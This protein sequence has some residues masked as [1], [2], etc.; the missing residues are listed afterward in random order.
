MNRL[1]ILLFA[2]TVMAIAVPA[3]ATL[4]DWEAAASA[5]SPGF[6]ATNVADGTYDIGTYGGEQTYEFVVKSNPDEVEP[7]MCLMG[8]RDSGDT[9]AGLKYEQW[10]NTGTYGATLFGV[11]DLDFGVAN[12]PGVETDIVFVSSA[13]SG[14][15]ALYVDGVYQASVDSAISLSGS[16]GIGYG[17]QNPDAHAGV[18]TFDNFDGEVLGVAVYDAAL[19]DD[20]IAAHSA[21]YFQAEAPAVPGPVPGDIAISTQAGWFSQDAADREMQKIVDNVTGASVEVFPA[22]QQDALADWVVAHTGDGAADL[23]ILCG[24]FPDSIYPSGNAQPDGSIAELFLDDG[25]IIIN[26][27]DYMFYVNSGGTNVNA[28]NGLYNMMDI[29][30]DMWDDDTPVAITAEG[31][32]VTPTLQDF[33]TDRPFHLDQL[34]GDWQPELIL[35][36]NAAGTRADPVIVVNTAT[37][38]RLGIF[39]QT[40]SQDNDPR[41]E[42]I[43]EWINNWYLTGGSIPNSSAINPVPEDGAKSVAIDTDLSW[44]AGIGAVSY[45]VYL[46]TEMPPA[47]LGS[48]EGTSIPA[49]T[50]EYGTTYYWSVDAVDENGN[51][52][53][54]DTWSFTTTVPVGIFEFTQD[55]GGPAGIGRTT[56]EGY[57]WKD[58][59]LTEQYLMMGGGADIWGNADQFHFAFNKV[60]GDIRLSASA[61]WIVASADWAKIGVMLRESTAGN[62]AHYYMCDRKL[63]DYAAV[64]G[65]PST[66]SASYE[67]GSTY[68]ANNAKG[69][70]IQRVTVNG[71]EW[72]EG[73]VDKGNGWESTALISADLADDL[74]AGVAIDAANNTQLVQARVWNIKYQLNPSMVGTI[75]TIPADQALEAPPTDVSGFSIRS[76]KTLVTNGS[77]NTF[78][79]MNELLDTGMFGGLPALPGSE[80]SRVDEFVNLRDTG[81]GLFSVDNGYPDISYPGIDPFEEPAQDP[82][83]GDDDN[84]FA[85]EI[86]GYIHLVPGEYYKFGVDSDDG[87]IL[88][89]G[90]VEVVRT[91]ELKGTSTVDSGI[92]IVDVEGYYPLRC[93]QFECTGGASVELHQILLDGTRLLMNDVAN[94]AA[95]VYAPAQ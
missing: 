10:N 67:Y 44:T 79:A 59:K 2:V 80:G 83:A 76:L 66:G 29:V 93:R 51:V 42:V 9:N 57:V 20:E 92:Y 89:I 17:I 55:I 19:S 24:N 82:A 60:S 95:E 45:N 77:F 73:L 6:I 30:V 26:T 65:R 78:A 33:A 74:L 53:P 31:H 23:L 11:V 71:V 7:S 3:N 22:D 41:G 49:G 14:T 88:E 32:A 47:L 15:T 13:A 28:S 69:L 94:G 18:A 68:N 62:S 46:G 72:I 5:A 63:R 52:L 75:P 8:R 12:N 34:T 90:G 21:A 4:N 56:Y 87:G 40:A 86:L 64:Q 39:Y 85:T 36:Q 61:G 37:G 91:A 35:A 1:I 43:S 38:G 58:D 54:S 27:G 25:N 70:G 50:L 81:N 48:V 16:V 84:Y